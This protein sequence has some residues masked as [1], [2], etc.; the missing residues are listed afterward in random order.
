MDGLRSRYRLSSICGE[1]FERYPLFRRGM[2]FL[3][4]ISSFTGALTRFFVRPFVLNSGTGKILRKDL[5][6]MAQRDIRKS[7]R[8][9]KSARL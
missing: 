8:G 3:L 6:E 2:S 4:S 9:K 1:A 7:E 5:R